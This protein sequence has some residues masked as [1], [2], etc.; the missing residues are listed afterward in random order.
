MLWKKQIFGFLVMTIVL[1]VTL[2]SCWSTAPAREVLSQTAVTIQRAHST[3]RAD[4]PMQ[5]FVDNVPYELANGV[6]TTI[7]LNSGEHI[8]HA[9]LGEGEGHKF[10]EGH[11]ELVSNSVKFVASSR[12]VIINVRPKSRLFRS[13]VLRIEVKQG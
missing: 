11:G 3:F 10:G 7:L 6:T 1:G 4:A 9:V 2:T 8:V 5:V 12:T 13:V